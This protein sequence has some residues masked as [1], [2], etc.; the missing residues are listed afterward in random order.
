MSS[1]A[2][3]YLLNVIPSQ[4]SHWATLCPLPEG[5]PGTASSGAKPSPPGPAPHT[6]QD[7]WLRRTEEARERA[8]SSTRA[9]SASGNRL[10]PTL[11]VQAIEAMERGQTPQRGAELELAD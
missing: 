2:P 8:L 4:Q 10:E 11:L 7:S 9:G 5:S 3:S 6:G 1:R